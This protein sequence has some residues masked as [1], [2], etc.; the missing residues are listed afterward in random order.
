M[1]KQVSLR[2]F[3]LFLLAGAYSAYA[4]AQPAPIPPISP[5][6]ATETAPPAATLLPSINVESTE[7]TSPSASPTQEVST[8]MG[9]VRFSIFFSPMQ[10]RAL[11]Q[12]LGEYE[13]SAP[14]K[15]EEKTDLTVDLSQTPEVP[16][17]VEPD[18]YPV[19][20]LSSIAYR[21]ANDWSI[22]V[23][24]HKITSQKN[25]TDLEVLSVSSSQASF[26]WKP[27]YAEVI[28]KR[29]KKDLFASTTEIANKLS[30][31]ARFNFDDTAGVA[32]FTLRPNQT[33][34]PAYMNSF[35]GF[36]ES[37]KLP[38]ITPDEPV[39]EVDASLLD[40]K[41]TPNG[42]PIDTT[43]NMSTQEKINAQLARQPAPRN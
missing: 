22:W 38:P 39:V 17:I 37:P 33:F 36:V 20:Y 26:A 25:N 35:E 12:A 11:E 29:K 31:P 3:S 30:K 40:E 43:A 28:T 13:G 32:T 19:F 27:D 41:P 1:L 10:M 4:I 21:A 16:K 24:G 5:A 14:I 9:P 18:T 15:S 7:Q 8:S 23:S 42:K 34:A 2:P 6:P